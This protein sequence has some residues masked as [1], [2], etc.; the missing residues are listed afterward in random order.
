MDVFFYESKF[1]TIKKTCYFQVSSTCLP[2]NTTSLMSV[3]NFLKKNREKWLK[4]EKNA[5]ILQ[6]EK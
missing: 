5:L 2:L 6:V 3:E 1:S 4:V